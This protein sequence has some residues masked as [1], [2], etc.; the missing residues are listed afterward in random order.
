LHVLVATPQY[1]PM[2]GGVE[3][4]VYE[5]TR[6][7]R[8]HGVTSEILTSDKT[9]RLPASEVIEGTCVRRVPAYPTSKDWLIAPRIPLAV[10]RGVDLVHVQSVATAVAPLAMVGALR[11]GLPYI[12]TFHTGGHSSAVRRS[13]RSAQWRALAPLLHRAAALI[14]VSEFEVELFRSVLGANTVPIHL[15]RNGCDIPRGGAPSSRSP[16]GPLVVSVGRLERYKGHQRVIRALAPLRARH[17]EAK[18]TIVGRG[19]YERQLRALAVDLGLEASVSFT[20]FDPKDRGALG[21]LV[22]TADALALLSE[23]EAH[24]VTVMEALAVGTP[25]LGAATTGFLEL[26]KAGLITTVPLGAAPD[27]VAQ[28]LEQTFGRQVEVGCLPSWDDCA[29]QLATLYRSTLLGP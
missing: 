23:Y 10:Q 7:L 14:G 2:L 16:A 28:S 1:L 11:A 6:R 20:S 9:R 27:L 13:L 29:A 15:V 3:T 25:V 5:T 4:H 26:A 19:P 12:V 21:D 24:P 22:S 18:L 8:P 17:P